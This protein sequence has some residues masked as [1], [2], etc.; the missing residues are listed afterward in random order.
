M[1]PFLF[2]CGSNGCMD[3]LASCVVFAN[4]LV[5]MDVVLTCYAGA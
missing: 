4:E 5:G 2:Q 1:S 3:E